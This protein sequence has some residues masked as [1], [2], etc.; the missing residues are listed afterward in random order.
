MID[1]VKLTLIGLNTIT[2]KNKNN[3]NSHYDKKTANL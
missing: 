1:K 3:N 2:K